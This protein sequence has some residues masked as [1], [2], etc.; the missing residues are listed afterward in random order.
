MSSRIYFRCQRGSLSDLVCLDDIPEILKECISSL[1]CYR[2]SQLSI[3]YC[4]WYKREQERFFLPS[5]LVQYRRWMKQGSN[6]WRMLSMTW[7]IVVGR[8]RATER[9]RKTG[10]PSSSKEISSDMSS[11]EIPLMPWK[12]SVI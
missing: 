11:T 6:D 5:S 3:L 10:Q 1:P 8:D 7:R 9:R 4:E 2:Y 12:T